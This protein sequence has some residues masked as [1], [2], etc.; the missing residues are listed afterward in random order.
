MSTLQEFLR[1]TCGIE[2]HKVGAASGH[3]TGILTSTR[4]TATSFPPMVQLEVQWQTA[5]KPFAIDGDSGNLI[6]AKDKGTVIPLGLHCGSKGTISYS[7][8]LQSI[9]QKVLQYRL[10]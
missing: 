7:L 4:R 5:E 9:C 1:K 6:F 10:P 3:T 2:V 8:S